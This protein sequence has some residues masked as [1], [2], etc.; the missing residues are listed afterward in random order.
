MNGL[1]GL[2]YQNIIE[3]NKYDGY[4]WFLILFIF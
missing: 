3:T 2:I 4:S 1:A